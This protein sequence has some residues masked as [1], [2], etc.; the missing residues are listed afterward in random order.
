MSHD[1]SE[2]VDEALPV[3]NLMKSINK[4][5][6]WSY[7]L[8]RHDYENGNPFVEDGKG[9]EHSQWRLDLSRI[10]RHY[11]IYLSGDV[12]NL[13]EHILYHVVSRSL[14]FGSELES[15]LTDREGTKS[16]HR[17]E[18]FR[19][20]TNGWR[21]EFALNDPTDKEEAVRMRTA[22][23]RII[24]CYYSILKSVSAL[25][26][27]KYKDIDQKGSG[28]S[29][30]QRRFNLHAE[31]FMGE[32]GNKLYTFPFMFFPENQFDWWFDW[33]VPYPIHEDYY[34]E[35]QQKMNDEAKRQLKRI[36][37]KAGNLSTWDENT[38]AIT[39]YDLLKELRDWANYQRGGILNR[40]YGETHQQ[41]IDNA[42]RLLSFTSLVIAEVGLIHA[43]GYETFREE[44]RAYEESCRAGVEDAAN[45]VRSRFVV[46]SQAFGD[47]DFSFQI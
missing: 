26:R 11:K 45:L 35:Q 3:G 27:T 43:F 39:T 47:S 42:L 30:H 29:P 7:E 22:E 28:P 23:W 16:E 17:K 24:Q 32:L 8:D 6:F 12:A 33:P 25:L 38:T 5:Y 41:A 14:E 20:L 1:A 37:G 18:S 21:D 36:Y 31:E 44:Y 15:F 34:E 19:N 46:Y 40:L 13:Q 10:R 2:F 9:M 4:G